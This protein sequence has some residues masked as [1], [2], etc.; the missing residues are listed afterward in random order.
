MIKMMAIAP[1]RL[2]VPECR[3]SGEL[4]SSVRTRRSNT[5]PMNGTSSD[6]SQA[7]ALSIRPEKL[8]L[9]ACDDPMV[10]EVR[11]IHGAH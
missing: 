4:M 3:L 9:S 5:V 1:D 7:A 6:W 8:G 2:R 11:S 10:I